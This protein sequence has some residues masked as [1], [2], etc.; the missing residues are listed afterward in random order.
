MRENAWRVHEEHRLSKVS[1]KRE[2]DPAGC[3][4]WIQDIEGRW[5]RSA[6]RWD[7][8]GFCCAFWRCSRD[9]LEHFHGFL[10]ISL[11]FVWFS[12][13]FW[14]LLWLVWCLWSSLDF[15]M[16]AD[17]PRERDAMMGASALGSWGCEPVADVSPTWFR[18]RSQSNASN[19][20]AS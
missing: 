4:H 14:W 20:M 12:C 8:G 13:D 1:S 10:W 18:L 2:R 17:H 3:G 15:L 7:V 9:F 19:W 16:E 5:V 11:D 6:L